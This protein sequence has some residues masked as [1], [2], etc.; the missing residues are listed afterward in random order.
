MSKKVTTIYVVAKCSDNC[1]V[2]YMNEKKET[3]AQ[4]HDYVPDFMP[5][6]HYGDYV[7]LEIDLATGKILNWRKPTQAQINKAIKKLPQED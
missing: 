4:G 2:K 3:V 7:E 5:G 6:E 1:H